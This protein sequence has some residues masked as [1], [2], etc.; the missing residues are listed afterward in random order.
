MTKNKSRIEYREMFWTGV[1]ITIVG[2][3]GFFL[4]GLKLIDYMTFI[5]CIP[6]MFAL[7]IIGMGLAVMSSALRDTTST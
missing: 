5:K 1:T 4:W 2:I 7:G 3:S 6:G